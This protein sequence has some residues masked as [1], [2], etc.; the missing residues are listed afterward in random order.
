MTIS[1]HEIP[2]EWTT[3][4]R[5]KSEKTTSKEKGGTA[6][7]IT[8]LSS[9]TKKDQAEGRGQHVESIR[10][11]PRKYYQ[12]TPYTSKNAF[13]D[14]LNNKENEASY[15]LNAPKAQSAPALA[16]QSTLLFSPMA[17]SGNIK[18]DKS[19]PSEAQRHALS[20][21]Q[22]RLQ[23][24]SSEL[25]PSRQLFS[26]THTRR[27]LIPL[28]PNPVEISNQKTNFNEKL[29]PIPE[30]QAIVTGKD[31]IS[32]LIEKP[33]Q[34]DFVQPKHL[35]DPFCLNKIQELSLN[36]EM[37]PMMADRVP[38]VLFS[39]IS[40]KGWITSFFFC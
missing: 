13:P 27:V 34:D 2:F 40:E 7:K 37:L 16:K 15:I 11:D 31:R 29:K 10:I 26:S 21:V 33:S 8:A 25:K 6:Q 24:P 20:N 38:E 35:S 39:Y 12:M 4:T 28:S 1:S 17:S 22:N 36:F 9:A 18:R 32:Q 30:D 3:N 19:T 23:T 14:Q 5:R